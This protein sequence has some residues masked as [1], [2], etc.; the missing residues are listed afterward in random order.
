MSVS[1]RRFLGQV[2]V[3]SAAFGLVGTGALPSPLVSARGR[4]ALWSPQGQGQGAVDPGAARRADRRLPRR[5]G[6]GL[7]R[8]N[9]PF[10]RASGPDAPPRLC[11]GRVHN[12]AHRTRPERYRSG[13]NGGASK[14]SCRVTGTWV[15]IP[16]SPPSLVERN[17]RSRCA[18]S[19][20]ILK[21]L[22]VTDRGGPATRGEQVVAGVRRGVRVVEGARL[23][24]VYTLIAYLGFES[25]SHRQ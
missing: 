8:Y 14:A 7:A 11:A 24:S 17:G 22:S 25:L 9:D 6:G 1:R 4:E 3:G 2:G 18:R 20:T 21:L 5:T 13:R 19:G 23:E 15:R 12:P 16:P 10:A